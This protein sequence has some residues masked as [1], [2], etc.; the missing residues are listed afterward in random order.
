MIKYQSMLYENLSV[1]LEVAKTLNQA[2]LLQVNS[3]PSEHDC[4]EIMD[5]VFSSQPALTNQP[6]SHPDVEY[7]M[8]S[9]SFVQDG[10]RFA[11]Y[12]DSK[13]AFTTIHV[14]G[15]LYKEGGSLTWEEKVLNMDKITKSCM[16]P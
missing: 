13:Y 3:G 15:A 16:S 12:T 9:N 7:F 4:L 6:I 2:T 10:T 8:Y 11:R 1:W 5:E 14:H